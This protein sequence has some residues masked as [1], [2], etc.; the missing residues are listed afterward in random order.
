MFATFGSP[1]A[2]NLPVDPKRG[3]HAVSHP[4][5]SYPSFPV[6]F[7]LR[8]Y[9]AKRTNRSSVSWIRYPSS[10]LDGRRVFSPNFHRP[11]FQ[12]YHPGHPCPPVDPEPRADPAL[13]SE[14]VREAERV[15]DHQVR[16]WEELDG[17]AEAL[18]RLGLATLAGAVA[19]ATFFLQEP[20]VRLG[21][22]FLAIF[23]AAGFLVVL[24]VLFFLAS[25]V[26]LRTDRRLGVGPSPVWLERQA[27]RPANGL[28]AHH[29]AV[30]AVHRT[31]FES[32]RRR[33]DLAVESRRRG[34]LLL[35]AGVLLYAAGFIYVVGATIL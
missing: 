25:Y 26:G 24:S 20:A 21:T 10:R 33:M 18:M 16:V 30:L 29:E 32:N 11:P 1:S 3:R 15:L 4:L 17:K 27:Q 22:V 14:L 19:L 35:T 31:D 5:P 9:P 34:S 2:V 23:V 7:P 12:L 8:P 28:A 6:P 13:L